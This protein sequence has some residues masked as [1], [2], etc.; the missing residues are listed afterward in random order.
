[1]KSR[2][3]P[4]RSRGA[5]AFPLF[6]QAILRIFQTNKESITMSEITNHTATATTPAAAEEPS[7]SSSSTTTLSESRLAANRENAQKSTGPATPEGK[8]KSSLNAVK[9]GLTGATVLFTNPDDAKNYARHVADYQYQFQPVGP[10]ERALVQS[11]ADIRWRLDTVPVLELAIVA[12][13]SAALIDADPE[14]W[15]KPENQT[16]LVLEVRRRH[17]RELRNL[18]LQ[19]NRL[20]RRRERESAELKGLQSA[21]KANEDEALAAGAR[22]ALLAQHRDPGAANIHIPGLGF[23]FSNDRFDVYMRR[24]KPAQMQIFLKEAL[25]A[26]PEA[27]QTREAAA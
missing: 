4:A 19:E 1:M 18:Q 5:G 23:D 14:T 21:R 10:E 15:A 2:A 16:S 8:A 6:P 20:A 7:E 22:A 17:E 13:G 11:I 3:T 9:H 27:T 26:E 12:E 24:L 25:A